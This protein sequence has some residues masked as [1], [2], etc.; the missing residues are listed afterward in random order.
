MFMY[1]GAR[2]LHLSS[3]S[4]V[5]DFV[6]FA[7]FNFYTLQLLLNY[8]AFSIVKLFLLPKIQSVTPII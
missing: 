8:A 7:F 4:S 3:F 5:T 2:Q 1:V 6:S